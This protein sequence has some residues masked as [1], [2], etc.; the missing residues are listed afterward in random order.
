ML[1]MKSSIALLAT[2]LLLSACGGNDSEQKANN[3]THRVAFTTT[4]E[5]NLTFQKNSDSVIQI[6]GRSS[7][8]DE[9]INA[10]A[11]THHFDKGTASIVFSFNFDKNDIANTLHVNYDPILKKVLNISIGE[12]YL[13]EKIQNLS[14][15]NLFACSESFAFDSCKNIDIK[16]DEKTGYSEI[17][18]VNT[19]LSTPNITSLSPI[20]EDK[21]STI[22]KSYISLNGKLSGFLSTPPQT[23]QNIRKTSQLNISANQQAISLMGA[24]YDPETSALFFSSH[25]DNGIDADLKLGKF[26]TYLK[27][28]LAIAS[29]L[30][31]EV[32]YGFSG[33]CMS[34]LLTIPVKELT[35]IEPTEN[36]N[37]ITLA[38][39]QAVYSYENNV[40][41]FPNMPVP[42]ECAKTNLQLDGSLKV[43][44][45]FTQLQITPIL[46]SEDTLH[47]VQPALY[48]DAT[49]HNIQKFG[50]DTIDVSVID[51]K[52]KQ[53]NFKATRNNPN[54]STGLI[55][56]E[57]QYNYECNAT[58][59]CQG[60]SYNPENNKLIFK[61]TMLTLKGTAADEVNKNIILNG[62]FDFAGR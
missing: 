40:P 24:I 23:L 6:S 36:S 35:S 20:N 42:S 59:S 7:N 25:T 21:Q 34:S 13:D 15:P 9:D 55:F 52:I 50:N 5:S 46:K 56:E 8:Q 4:F 54:P 39:N 41:L 17:N 18:F 45:P 49:N 1:N 31:T 14:K 44:K 57:I 3:T 2:S 47:F 30:Q 27:D 22:E 33:A 10:Y 60:V 43:N 61:N 53:I 11:V 19:K 16:F 58:Q 12:N 26:T 48:F 51:N 29:S 37:D 38:F 28:N 32:L 62:I